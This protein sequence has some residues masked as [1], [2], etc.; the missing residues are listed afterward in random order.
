MVV[1]DPTCVLFEKVRAT[2]SKSPTLAE[3]PGV[4]MTLPEGRSTPPWNQ[5]ETVV[6]PPV[7]GPMFEALELVV[8]METTFPVVG[9][10][11]TFPLGASTRPLYPSLPITI[12]D[13]A[14]VMGLNCVTFDEPG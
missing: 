8:L 2:G 11:I 1:A 7:T 4:N 9:T 13:W 10:V 3:N 6:P 14:S 5:L 12:F